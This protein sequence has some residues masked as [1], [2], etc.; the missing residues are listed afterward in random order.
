M[1]IVIPGLLKMSYSPWGWLP[2]FFAQVALCGLF[3]FRFLFSGVL[4]REIE[5]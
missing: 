3:R 1:A 4:Q 5:S 2:A